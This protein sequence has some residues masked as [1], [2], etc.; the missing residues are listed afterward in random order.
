MSVFGGLPDVFVGTFGESV[1]YNGQE[2]SGIWIERPL[3]V[4]NFEG[5]SVEAMRTELHVRDADFL[6]SPVEGDT[7]ERN[8][9]TYRVDAPP[10]F[11]GKGMVILTL[12]G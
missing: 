1:A 6:V 12:A 8:G 4:S 7:V 3:L 10:R 2:I 5:V 9:K 11:D